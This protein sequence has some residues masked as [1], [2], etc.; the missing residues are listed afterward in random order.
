MSKKK[1][2]GGKLLRG[3]LGFVLGLV[4]GIILLVLAIG[5]TVAALGLTRTV[6]ELQ[7]AVSSETIISSDSELYGQTVLEAV[8]GLLDDY[9]NFDEFSLEKLY[10]KYGINVFNG[11][12]GVDFSQKNFYKKPIGELFNDM[13]LLLEDIYLSDISTLTGL[14]FS[15]YGIPIIDENM[16]VGIQTLLDNVMALINNDLSIRVIQNKLGL[17][18]GVE[19]NSILTA[20]QDVNLKEIG[21]LI[22]ALR[23]GILLEADTDTFLPRK[24]GLKVYVNTVGTT[25]EWEEITQNFT[26]EA[27][28]CKEGVE[29]FI[30]GGD[31]SKLVEKET[32]YI[33]YEG[34]D[35]K[36]DN[37]CYSNDEWT[38][39]AGAKVYRRRLF[40]EFDG[41]GVKD[42]QYFVE[43]FANHIATINGNAYTLLHKDFISLDDLY[44][45]ASGTKLDKTL[46]RGGKLDLSNVKLYYSVGEGKYETSEDFSILD[47]TI[48][49]SSLL[50]V[51]D[52]PE[53]GSEPEHPYIA[54]RD[55]YIRAHFGTATPLLQ[56]LCFMTIGE[57]RTGTDS[58]LKTVRIGDIVDTEKEGTAEVLKALKDSTL[59]SIGSDINK[60]PFGQMIPN[61]A[62]NPLLNAISDCTLED[63]DEKINTLKLGEIID[64]KGN[65]LLE[66]LA[67]STLDS[68]SEDVNDLRINQIIEITPESPKLLCALADRE[69]TL[70]NMSDVIE[71]LTVGELLDVTY[72]EYELDAEGDYVRIPVYV[73]L[74]PDK[75]QDL[76]EDKIYHDV[77]GDSP[78]GDYEEGVFTENADGLWVKTYYYALYDEETYAGQD[79]DRYA[80]IERAKTA[81]AVQSLARR[82]VRALDMGNRLNDLTIGEL[83]PID[84]DSAQL[85]KTLSRKGSTLETIADDANDLYISDLI[86]I[87]DDSSTI[88]RSLKAR[89]CKLS[90]MG[91]ITDELTL[92]EMV[93][94][95]EDEYAQNDEGKYV[96]V[97]DGGSYEPY[98]EEND[99]DWR[100]K[101]V[102]AEDG[103]Y[104]PYDPA[105]HTGKDIF[106]HPAY[107]TL[108]N[109]AVHYV[110]GEIEIETAGGKVVRYEKLPTE[111]ASSSIMQRFANSQME[112]FSNAFDE[113]LLSDVMDIPID[114]YASVD[115][116]DITE[117]EGK[118]IVKHGETEITAYFYDPS[119]SV[120]CIA[121]QDE[122]KQAKDGNITLYYI[123]TPGEGTAILRKLAFV[124]VSEMEGAMEAVMKDLMLSEIIDVNTY[125]AVIEADPEA[126]PS[127]DEF[128][129]IEWDGKTT[130]NGRPAVYVYDDTA[131]GKYFM[132]KFYDEQIKQGDSRL[133]ENGTIHYVY[134]SVEELKTGLAASS[135]AAFEAAVLLK[136]AEANIFVK[137]GEDYVWNLPYASYLAA[138]LTLTDY[139]NLYYREKVEAGTPDAKAVT[140]YD[141]ADGALYVS[142]FGQTIEY[143]PKNPAHDITINTDLTGE[144]IKAPEFKFFFRN[145]SEDAEEAKYLAPIGDTKYGY[146]EGFAITYGAQYCN[147][148]FFKITAADVDSATG[149]TT[150]GEDIYVYDGVSYAEYNADLHP[151]LQ[152][153]SLYIKKTGYVASFAESY[154]MDD[155]DS[156]TTLNP[157][158]ITIE[159]QRSS[160]VLRLLADKT[161]SDMNSAIESATMGD[162][163]EV[164]PGTIFDN[165]QIRNA[166]ITELGSTLSEVFATMTIGELLGWSNISGVDER[167][168]QVL[169]DIT[170]TD[171]FKSLTFDAT[172]G[173]IVIDM[174]KLY[175]VG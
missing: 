73:Q 74:D 103:G 79:I 27:T 51:P 138:K 168:V 93:D 101:F 17:E 22:D 52:A 57:L 97:S 46:I 14:D 40:K 132:S 136:V 172:Q 4:F 38:C 106:V 148:V 174:N 92:K 61:D 69:A 41:N 145:G 107:Y 26:Q 64:A 167:V 142:A 85:F 71:K 28:S 9:Q 62:D 29:T 89:H 165:E 175:G 155:S 19:N 170:L 84:K 141:N 144:N 163:I 33:K 55:K 10:K 45:S 154:Y 88:M 12:S 166:T 11:I 35:Y 56:Y 34:Q 130:I 7:S 65:P 118:Y 16:N 134:K 50:R 127:E 44:Q 87:N 108:Y 100:E 24:S 113:I 31:Q 54:G 86:E 157:I 137:Q 90:E 72:D 158:H 143:D 76:L 124:K 32:R 98:D 120:Y 159:R 75:D 160:S 58:I 109:P 68:I 173:T 129:F 128:Y 131:T 2:T 122:L 80:L 126:T 49:S 47:K 151:D 99:D 60:I 149:K 96:K 152:E 6:G 164:T 95:V 21:G 59:D 13:S 48:E 37:S 81:L 112:A 8:M 110:N 42:A 39:P 66:A 43:G 125:D 63:I 171:F 115:A 123:Q 1:G 119:V 140:I 117:Q 104:E 135:D 94:I 67:E 5:G 20:L 105:T 169:E 70:E 153:L 102:K 23:I 161:I 147:D 18:F 91:N 121:G 83:M 25:S 82:G 156:V 77:F 139:Q 114:I 133:K 146:E 3:T 162:F 15:E 30:A 150:E 116:A 53:D 111:G 78:R 36:V